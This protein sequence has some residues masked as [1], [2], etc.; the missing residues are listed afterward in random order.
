MSTG[1][2]KGLLGKLFAGAGVMFVAQIASIFLNYSSKIII[3]RFLGASDYG[4]ITLG[5]TMLVFVSIF[6][7]LGLDTAISRFLPRFEDETRRRGVLVSSFQMGIVLSTITGIFII[8][9]AGWISSALLR[10]PEA[11]NVLRVFGLTVPIF[12]TFKLALGGIRGLEL[13]KP[14]VYAQNFGLPLFRLA[15]FILVVLIGGGVITFAL[16]Y[17]AAYSVGALIGIYYLWRHTRIFDRTVQSVSMHKE[18]LTFSMPLLIS[19][20]M[21]RVLSYGD[22]FLLSNLTASSATV[23]VYNVI[24][25]LSELILVVLTAFGYLTL[26][27]MSRLDSSRVHDTRDDMIE[28]YSILTKWIFIV[29]LPLVLAMTVFPTTII[30]T[31]FGSD[32][33]GGALALQII[34][35]GFFSHAIVGPNGNVLQSIGK[36]RLLMIDNITIAALN[37]GLNIVLIPMFGL[38]GAAIATTVSYILMNI[39]YSYQLYQSTGIQPL[40]KTMLV[41][42]LSA[43]PAFLLLSW[44]IGLFI[45]RSVLQLLVVLTAFGAFYIAVLVVFGLNEREFELIDLFVNRFTE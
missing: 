10:V 35:L 6:V 4:L 38:E 26:P 5:N 14:S 44:S 37:V 17:S 24:Y 22:I 20:I 28:I 32:Y 3:A 33:L 2:V 31:L 18:L 42:V 43:L 13:T 30:G 29:T 8:V 9:S 41:I 40:S 15:F 16:S 19:G 1:S 36:T 11:E 34:V 7:I 12:V 25:S 23:G 39:V 21:F 27:I 45:E